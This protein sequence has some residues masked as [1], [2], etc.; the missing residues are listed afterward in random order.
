MMEIRMGKKCN[1][2]TV[3]LSRQVGFRSQ[4]SFSSS[5]QQLTMSNCQDLHFSFVYFTQSTQ[6]ETQQQH[7][8]CIEGE[9]DS[10]I[11]I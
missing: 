8:I 7:A 1:L 10:R 11:V 2:S 6:T 9:F 3:A 5:F 4:L